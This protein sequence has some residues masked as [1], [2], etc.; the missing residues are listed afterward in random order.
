MGG[1]ALCCKGSIGICATSLEGVETNAIV[2]QHD[3]KMTTMVK[4]AVD[5][6]QLPVHVIVVRVGLL[7]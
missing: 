7:K 6:L 2:G 4:T 1:V 3:A 5:I